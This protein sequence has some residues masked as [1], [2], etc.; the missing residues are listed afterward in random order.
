M[1]GEFG[2][3][4]LA[5]AVAYLVK[6]VAGMGGPLLAVP[7]IASVTSVE[8][9]VVVLSLANMASNG[10]LLWEHRSGAR[11]TGFVMTPF[12]IVGTAATIAGTWLLTEVDDR[13][14]SMVIAVVIVGYIWRYLANP[15]FGLKHDTARRI[16]APMGLV[17]GGL[18]GATGTAGPLIAT[19]LHSLRMSRSSLVYMMTIT[20]QVFGL[21]QLATL[22]FLGAFTPERTTQA[23]WAIVPVAIVT[24]LGIRLGRRLDQK[25]FEYVVLALLG[26]AAVRLVL[27][28]LS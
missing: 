14:L 9:A 11:G 1:T 18:L 25:A 22:V 4:L 26:F 13:I 8:H 16:A 15:H 10:W 5:I 3:I 23:L 20:F 21:I 19:Y 28:A 12:L 24:F 2:I 17:G 7:V 27:S 6:G